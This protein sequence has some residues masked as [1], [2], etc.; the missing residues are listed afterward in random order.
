MRK[1]YGTTKRVISLQSQ[2]QNYTVSVTLLVAMVRSILYLDGSDK[3]RIELSP[4]AAGSDVVLVSLKSLEIL[5][6]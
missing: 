2:N 3:S 6:K 4:A 5:S 1:L